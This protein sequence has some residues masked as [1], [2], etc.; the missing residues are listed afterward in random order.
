MTNTK[1]ALGIDVEQFKA[2]AANNRAIAKT[3]VSAKAFAAVER[4]RVNA[5]IRVVFDSF[6]FVD[7]DGETI[8]DPDDLYL[9]EDDD[10]CTAY[11]AACDA[12]HRE[13]GFDGP[14]GHCP[15]LIAEDLLRQAEDVLL[16][17]LGELVNID[18]RRFSFSLDLRA[19][20]LDLALSSC[21]GNLV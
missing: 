18:G 10:L 5:Y 16:G 20:A 13:N 1:N 12:A 3:V 15:A 4:E 7:E 9:C 21:L 8:T 11:Y 6:S 17:S 2:W 19:K 14:E